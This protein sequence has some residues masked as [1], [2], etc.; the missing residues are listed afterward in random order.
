MGLDD[1]LYDNCGEIASPSVVVQNNGSDPITSLSIEY[2]IND[3]SSETYSWTGSIASLEFTSIE[4][5]S[6][7]YRPF[8]AFLVM[9]VQLRCNLIATLCCLLE[10]WRDN[11]TSYNCEVHC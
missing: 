2:S 8:L 1:N 11:S 5:P 3:G 10:N 6:I 9:A 4:L 7:G